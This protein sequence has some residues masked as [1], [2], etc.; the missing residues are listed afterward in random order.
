MSLIKKKHLKIKIKILELTSTIKK[1][2]IDGVD[3]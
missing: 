1:L 2:K 3:I